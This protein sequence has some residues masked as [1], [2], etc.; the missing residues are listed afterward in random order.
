MKIGKKVMLHRLPQRFDYLIYRALSVLEGAIIRQIHIHP[1]DPPLFIVGPP[2]SG[3]TAMFLFVMNSWY[4]S[5]F[6]NISK[7]HSRAPFSYAAPYYLIERYRPTFENVY[8][9]LQQPMA[10][11]DGWN[12]Y[13]RWFK[14]E[15]QKD[16]P[17]N[18]IHELVTLSRLFEQ[19]M[20]GPFCVRNNVNSLRIHHLNKLFPEA[21]FL[22]IYRNYQESA[23]S[24]KE[25]YIA[26][27]TADNLW[28]S[29]GP[30]DYDMNSFDTT[31]E[32]A[33][34]QVLG[35]E[36]IMKWMIMDV[37]PER[38]FIL[39][40]EDLCNHPEQVRE[41]IERTYLK[42]GARLKRTRNFEDVPSSIARSS[43]HQEEQKKEK[44]NL[45]EY[46]DSFRMGKHL[47]SEVILTKDVRSL[48][49]RDYAEDLYA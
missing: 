7:F 38:K 12:I 41:W 31:L 5:Y 14:N 42:A 39:S 24:L 40:Y 25:A 21:L 46:Y 22:A 13:L 36:A 15:F 37:E 20:S 44:D 2:R 27:G 1:K 19:L 30:P 6:P 43:R 23:L 29:A 45:E 10:P 4:L 11:S 26:H 35:V 17:Q 33:V 18:R 49:Q 47:L 32:K 16:M 48:S 9:A 34:H 3:T 28:W 8:G